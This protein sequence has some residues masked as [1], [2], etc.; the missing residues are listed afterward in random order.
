[1]NNES[2]RWS[3]D[4]YQLL[5]SISNDSP[6]ATVAFRSLGVGKVIEDL[7][8]RVITQSE[9]YP[10]Y[11]DGYEGNPS[12]VW[13]VVDYSVHETVSQGKSHFSKGCIVFYYRPV[14]KMAVI[15]D[16]FPEWLDENG[17]LLPEY[18]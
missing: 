7:V 12:H 8:K 16:C 18:R 13:E 9:Q 10:T 15:R 3:L 5:S 11:T 1:M 6:N 17:E 2:K 14:N 4:R